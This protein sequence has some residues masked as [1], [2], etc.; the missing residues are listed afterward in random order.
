MSLNYIK[1]YNID[2]VFDFVLAS[3][4]DQNQII[5]LFNYAI[6]L[7]KLIKKKKVKRGLKYLEV[8]EP[9]KKSTESLEYKKELEELNIKLLN[10]VNELYKN[11]IMLYNFISG[12]NKFI[13]N[14]KINIF[15][16]DK[17]NIIDYLLNPN[18]SEEYE[19]DFQNTF[20]LS[21]FKKIKYEEYTIEKIEKLSIDE[22]ENTGIELSDE[23]EKIYKNIMYLLKIGEEFN[24]IDKPILEAQKEEKK[25]EQEVQ[26]VFIDFNPNIPKKKKKKTNN[27]TNTKIRNS[28]STTSRRRRSNQ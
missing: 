24:K 28:S 18:S 5:E 10:T 25:P 19:L 11:E 12:I 21:G 15:A 13:E 2:P 7:S 4:I 27:T 22:L 14:N 17:E 20:E 26:P 23:I 3:H 8:G 9:Y 1:G 16:D 6:E